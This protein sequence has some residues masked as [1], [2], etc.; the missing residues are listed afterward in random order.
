MTSLAKKSKPKTKN[1]YQR[2]AKVIEGFNSSVVQSLA[3]IFPR[4]T[5]ANCWTLASTHWKHGR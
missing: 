1:F 5:C 4:K 2:L 3:E